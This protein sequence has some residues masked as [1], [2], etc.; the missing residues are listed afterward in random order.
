MCGRFKRQNI[1]DQ[2]N[3]TSQII[4]VN[5]L[6]NWSHR[7]FGHYI[8]I[9]CISIEPIHY[10]INLNVVSSRRVFNEFDYVFISKVYC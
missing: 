9:K 5:M 7:Y 8:I 3:I 6:Q 2:T 4:V 1:F 10:T